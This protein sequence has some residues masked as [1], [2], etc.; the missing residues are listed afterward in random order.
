MTPPDIA[1]LRVVA[2][3]YEV[4]QSLDDTRSLRTIISAPS[5]A[6][7]H[8][9]CGLEVHLKERG[10]IVDEQTTRNSGF[11]LSD[12]TYADRHRAA[13]VAIAAGQVT[14]DAMT[15]RGKLFSEDLW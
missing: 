9:L 5:L 11:L 15:V 2:A 1:G 6:R 14:V 8:N 13:E 12:G 7:H 3:A 4:L 10:M